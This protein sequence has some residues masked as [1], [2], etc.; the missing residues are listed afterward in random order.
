MKTEGHVLRGFVQ[1]HVTTVVPFG[2]TVMYSPLNEARGN[3]GDPPKKMGVWLG[4]IGRT[5]DVLIATERGAAK[6]RTVT[7]LPEGEQWSSTMLTKIRGLLWEFVFGKQSHHTPVATH[8]DGGVMDEE[9]ETTKPKIKLHGEEDEGERGYK[10]NVEGCSKIRGDGGMPRVRRH[11]EK[12]APIWQIGI[13]PFE[14]M[15]SQSKGGH[16]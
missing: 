15:Q 16:E 4:T 1:S 9:T 7:R 10:T 12:G 5:E 2:E 8:E 6:C 11:W 3:N 14:R 13:Q